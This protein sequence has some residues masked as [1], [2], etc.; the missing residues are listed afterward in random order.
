M[1]FDLS[2]VPASFQNYISK[3]LVKKV[4]VFVIIYQND[5]LT[6]IKDWA[7]VNPSIE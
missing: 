3:I 5:I 1:L 4:D 6:Y 2:N 7:S